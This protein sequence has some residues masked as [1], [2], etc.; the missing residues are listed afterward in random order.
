MHM[1]EVGVSQGA[2]VRVFVSPLDFGITCSFPFFFNFHF[3]VFRFCLMVWSSSMF[4]QRFLLY[5]FALLHLLCM[6]VC[7]VIP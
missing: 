7:S 1:V 5:E 4:Y 6:C 3:M 2:S